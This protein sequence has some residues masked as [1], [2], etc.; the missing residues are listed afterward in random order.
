MLIKITKIVVYVLLAV[1]VIL[2]IIHEAMP[3]THG[4]DYI[5]NSLRVA[6]QAEGTIE[7]RDSSATVTLDEDEWDHV[8]NDENDLFTL[9]TGSQ[10]M[11]LTGD[12]LI[13]YKL[14]LIHI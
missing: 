9:K 13:I 5:V 6:G 7:F 2:F 3:Q 1:A 12:S 8:T 4:V 14:S 11:T 10:N